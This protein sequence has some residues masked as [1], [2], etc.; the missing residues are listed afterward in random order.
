MVPI[1]QLAARRAG[2][3]HLVIGTTGHRDLRE[4][5]RPSLEARVRDI[6]VG[7]Q[8]RYSN[9]PLTLLSPLAEG[10][11]RLVAQVALERGARLIVPLPM[12]RA[13]YEED[14]AAPASRAEFAALV[15][16]ADECFVAPLPTGLDAGTTGEARDRRYA[17]VGAYVVLHAQVLIALW[18][19]R[20]TNLVGGTAEIIRFQLE[21]VPEPY[22]PPRSPLDAPETGPVY[23]IV[24]PRLS[25]PDVDGPLSLRALFPRGYV[26]DAGAE[27]AFDRIYARIDTFNR[28]ALA[29]ESRLTRARETSRDY[30]LPETEAAALPPA[31]ASARA[32]YAV[33][34]ALALHFQ[35][36]T[37]RTLHTLLGL[38]FLAALLF[39]VYDQV[40]DEVP[41][42][43]LLHGLALLIAY[44]VYRWA[45]RREYEVKYLDYRALA[46]G[47]RV[48]F[49]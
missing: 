5:D 12:A 34:D 23:N 4:E 25:S 47:L 2:P 45:R 49:F 32:C 31:L 29:L 22:A 44:M 24:T 3:L 13:E 39:A 41:E 38:V 35:R 36:L 16:R 46:E 37:L 19:G 28:D 21:G 8:T 27:A 33:A 43:W 18:D 11:D 10:A 26:D 9:T 7:L 15:E 20:I 1:Q 42:V 14:F 17:N 48:Q 40:Q 6:V 30:L